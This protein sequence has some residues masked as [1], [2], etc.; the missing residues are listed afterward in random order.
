[1]HCKCTHL[2]TPECQGERTTAYLACQF[3]TNI[4]KGISGN[5]YYCCFFSINLYYS[6]SD[7]YS[8]E[9]TSVPRENL[10]QPL[11][12]ESVELQHKTLILKF[13]Y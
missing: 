4:C 10:S 9:N 11:L 6:G 8:P 13:S 2:C 7:Y 1:M 5:N 3:C 12:Y